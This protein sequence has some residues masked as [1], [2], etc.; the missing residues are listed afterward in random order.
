MLK[1]HRKFCDRRGHTE[2]RCRQKNNSR[3][4]V[5]VN[6]RNNRGYRS[7]ANMTNVSQLNTEE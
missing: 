2:D 1:F 7:S 3:R 6:Q 4:A 5:Q